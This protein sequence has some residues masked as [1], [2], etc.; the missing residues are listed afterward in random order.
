MHSLLTYAP[1]VIAFFIATLDDT[2]RM[3]CLSYV[4]SHGWSTSCVEKATDVS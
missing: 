2:D 4:K 1:E 3:N